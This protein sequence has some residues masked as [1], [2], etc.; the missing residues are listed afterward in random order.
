MKT[1]RTSFAVL[2]C[3]LLVNASWAQEIKWFGESPAMMAAVE[4]RGWDDIGFNRLPA[5]SEGIVR[6]PVWTLSRQ[7]AGLSLHF[8]TDSPEIQVSYTPTSSRLEMPHMPAT[9]VS[10]V[11]LYVKDASGKLLWVRGNYQFA[12]KITYKFQLDNDAGSSKEFQLFLPL[13]NGLSE[14]QIGIPDDKAFAFIPKRTE[15]PILVYGTSIAQGACASRAGMAWANI[16]SREMNLPMINL[17]F[18]GNGR[19]EEEVI[20]Y[21]SQIDPAVFVLD[22]LP[23]L[24]SFSESEVKNKLIYAVNTLR[25]KYPTTPI[26]LTEHAGY[27]DGLVYEPRAEI[28][29]NLNNW[30]QQS[31]LE[32]RKG[33]ITNVFMLTKD[34]LDLGTDDFVDGTHPTDLGMAKYASAYA[35]K[36]KEI[37]ENGNQY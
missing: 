27:S 22:C 11:D 19:M 21:V 7:T 16:L 2:I 34:E 25:S 36:L 31:F 9:G 24:G 6:D 20:E 37:V 1:T 29:E 8:T 4:G 35:K 15:K 23:N 14:L 28:Y 5:S 3:I 17:A 26:L 32:L 10:G 30:L 12:E 18:S 13:Y 33:G